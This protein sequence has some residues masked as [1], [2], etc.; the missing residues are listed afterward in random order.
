MNAQ[1]AD[2]STFDYQHE[3]ERR[4]AQ[5]DGCLRK[6]YRRAH[7][8]VCGPCFLIFE[9]QRPD[10]DSGKTDLAEAAKTELELVTAAFD[11]AGRSS[12]ATIDEPFE[13]S[14]PDEGWRE[15]DSQGRFIQFSFEKN[16]F[17][18]D[19]P[20]NTLYR[21]EAEQIMRN[22]NGFFYLRDRPE[23]TLYGEDVDGYDP[24]RKIYIYGDEDSAAEET[25]FIFFQVWRFP[26]DS[27]FYV[28]AAAFGDKKS[29]WECGQRIE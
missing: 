10:A 28:T 19:M 20:L 12:I 26:L 18:M 2:G 27:R 8:E 25:A 24:F 5:F 3:L 1:R 6:M 13:V 21:P 11:T 14:L 9:E 17:C 29:N 22:R 16:W 15:D 7:E 4:I 23:F